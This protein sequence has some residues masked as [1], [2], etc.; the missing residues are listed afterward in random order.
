MDK[1]SLLL[2]GCGDLGMRAAGLLA[3]ERWHIC[4]VRRHPPKSVGQGNGVDEWFARDYSQPGSLG[5]IEKL[6]PDFVAATFTPTSMDLQGYRRG[7]AEGA[8]NL[9]SGL[10]GHRPRLLI[11]VSSTRVYAESDGGWVDESSA[12]TTT[13]ERGLA[14]VEAERQFLD[15]GQAVSVL[16]CGGIYGAPGG[17]LLNKIAAGRVAP[18]LPLRYT[19]RIH[20]DDCAGFMVHLLERALRGMTVEP[21]YNVVDDNPAPAHDVEA[22]IAGRLGLVPAHERAAAEQGPVSHKRCRN[23][24]LHNSGYSLRYPDYRAGYRDVCIEARGA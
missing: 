14:I 1:H 18:E 8:S 7:F 17:R 23:D 16:R 24:L 15:S 21:V 6:A 20:R 22:W 2:V 12:L 11:M 5:F 9:L 3:L 13:D 10:G 4:G 19:N